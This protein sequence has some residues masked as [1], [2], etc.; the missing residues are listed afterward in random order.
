V[1][2]EHLVK[3]M[4][5][6]GIKQYEIQD[7]QRG[8]L[9]CSCPLAPYTHGGGIDTNP[10]FGF[11]VNESGPSVYYCFGCSRQPRILGQLLHRIFLLSDTYPTEAGELYAAC[12]IFEG[13]DNRLLLNDA[14]DSKPT[15]QVMPLPP[16]VI[17]KYPLLQ[18]GDDFEAKRCRE[19][20]E[21]RGIPEYMQNAY[22][23]RYS[24]RDSAVIFPMTDRHGNIFVLRARSR[25]NKTMWTIGPKQAGFD[26]VVFPKIKEVGC[27][28]GM[29]F[30]DWRKPVVL[31]EGEIDALRLKAL[32]CSYNTI[33]SAS[34]SITESQ[35][36]AL[37]SRT[38]ITGFDADLAGWNATKIVWERIGDKSLL[39]QADWGKAGR[40]DPGALKSKEE[41][42]LV[43]SNLESNLENLGR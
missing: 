34:S 4:L 30:V 29:E 36:L 20:L 10:S 8:W 33:A 39:R 38:T 43:L 16:K 25:R 2:K 18:M 14:W 40:K 24:Y 17:R 22:R 23:V 13:D 6:L 1:I 41:M 32:R 7:T 9:Q 15:K 28:F 27:W 21:G 3:F 42:D 12:E 35:I 26:D 5:L 11:S 19:F 37:T 31:V